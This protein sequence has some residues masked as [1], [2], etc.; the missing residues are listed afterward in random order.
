[1]KT[2]SRLNLLDDGT[3]MIQNTQ[4]TDQGIYQCMAKNVAGQVKTQEVTLRYFESP[5]TCGG[6]HAGCCRAALPRRARP[7]RAAGVMCWDTAVLS[8]QPGA[9]RCSLASLVLGDPQA[10]LCFLKKNPHRD[11]SSKG[12]ARVCCVSGVRRATSCCFL[13]TV[14]AFLS[15]PRG[16][17]S[18]FS[19]A[20]SLEVPPCPPCRCLAH[21]V[22]PAFLGDPSPK[23]SPPAVSR[24]VRPSVHACNTPLVP[25][26]SPPAS[27]SRLVFLRLCCPAGAMTF[28]PRG[29][30]VRPLPHARTGSQ[31]TRP[32][33]RSR[34]PQILAA[35]PCGAAWG[36]AG[37]GTWAGLA[38]RTLH[39]SAGA[40]ALLVGSDAGVLVPANG[41]TLPRLPCQQRSREGCVCVSCP[42]PFLSHG[43]PGPGA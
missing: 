33:A 14:R 1:M 21:S 35:C 6:G 17:L 41:V 32:G 30:G 43:V 31:V 10:L 34:L 18:P 11:I 5:G 3:L 22:S 42:P 20:A 4:E 36:S 7:R 15:L 16:S 37:D 9:L 29:A 23:F 27:E 25:G 38:S 39:V 19:V 24:A 28:P 8:P 26:P 40:R 13:G 2:D 12:P